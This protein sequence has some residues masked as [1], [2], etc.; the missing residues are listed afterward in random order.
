MV[1]HRKLCN[2]DFMWKKNYKTMTKTMEFL[3]TMD[4][5]TVLYRKLGNLYL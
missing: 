4:K 2:F 1:L 5:T 3:S